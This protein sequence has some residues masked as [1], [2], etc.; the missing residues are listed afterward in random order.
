MLTKTCQYAIRA[1][2]YVAQENQGDKKIRLKEI[3]EKLNIPE[4]FLGKV[5]Q[6]LVR[7]KILQ[8]VKG[9]N[10]G[11]YISEND[12]KQPLINIVEA[13]DGLSIFSACA[14]GL[15]RCSDLNPCPIHNKIIH[16]RESFQQLLK[17]YSIAKTKEGLL[18]GEYFIKE[19]R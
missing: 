16:F 4:C 17:T 11:F 9:P 19:M 15:D 12:L 3:A 18:N 6:N 13:V 8:S 1:T 10:G 7:R 14:L 5:M 2:L